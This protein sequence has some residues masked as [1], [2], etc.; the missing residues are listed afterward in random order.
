MTFFSNYVME[1]RC[2]S[3]LEAEMIPSKWYEILVEFL[4]ITIL[5]PIYYIYFA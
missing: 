5:Y 3:G 4:N 1:A 2:K